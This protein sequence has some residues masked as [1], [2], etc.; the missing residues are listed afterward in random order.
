VALQ[1]DLNCDMGEGVA[2]FSFGHDEELM[3]SISSANIACGWHGGDPT[4]MRR[5]VQL[6]LD[7]DVAIG[8]HVGFPDL[9]GFGLHRMQI[10]PETAYDWTLYQV[11]ALKA[12]VEAAGARLQHVKPHAALYFQ[13]VEDA[14]LT[15]AVARAT[16][17]LGD[18]VALVLMGDM[19]RAVAKRVGVPYVA[20]GFADMRY[21][22]EV[23]LGPFDADDS[24][25]IAARAVRLVV[26]GEIELLDGTV[27]QERV[28]TLCIHGHV[29]MAASNGR[30]VRERLEQAGVEIVPLT[31]LA[32]AA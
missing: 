19:P 29:P 5:T 4:V 27:H 20:E 24:D 31:Q 2:L 21:T 10:S 1:L 28:S 15:E 17:D 9:I 6:A 16:K 32:V 7:H 8:A 14:E 25:A 30:R 18:D 13:C 3:K 26:D 22:P 11:G 23:R 12:F